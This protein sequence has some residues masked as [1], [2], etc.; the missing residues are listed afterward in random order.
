ML[1]TQRSGDA[2]VE[3]RKR[4]LPEIAGRPKEFDASGAFV[5]VGALDADDATFLLFPSLPVEKAQYLAGGDASI[6]NHKPTMR[7]DALHLRGFAEKLGF[8]FEC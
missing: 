2:R 4:D 1:I 6:Q 3:R 8:A 5:V 7:A